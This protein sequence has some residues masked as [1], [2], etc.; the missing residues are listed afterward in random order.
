MS[1][2]VSLSL[3][4]CFSLALAHAAAHPL[5]LARAPPPP[6]TLARATAL[7]SPR[8]SRRPPP[9]PVTCA[10]V[11]SP[12]A[13]QGPPDAGKQHR[14]EGMQPGGGEPQGCCVEEEHVCRGVEGARPGSAAVHNGWGGRRRRARGRLCSL[15][16]GGRRW[17][18]RCKVAICGGWDRVEGERA[19]GLDGV[20]GERE[21]GGAWRL[22]RNAGSYKFCF[23]LVQLAR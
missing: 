9:R 13:M 8:A 7:I 17:R 19:C 3:R 16:S 15:S 1:Q 5:A 2:G 10:V 21:G 14:G 20:G 4:V 23:V 22:E 11:I 6:L 12:R 18:C